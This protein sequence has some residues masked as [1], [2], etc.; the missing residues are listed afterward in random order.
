MRTV[1]TIL[2]LFLIIPVSG[3]R[4][5][6]RPLSKTRFLDS[7]RTPKYEVLS[8]ALH[9]ANA[10]GHA[11]KYEEA[12]QSYRRGYQT[13]QKWG[14]K[15]LAAQFLSGLGTCQF[16]S[17]RYGDALESYVAVRKMFEALGD[18]TNTARV[19]L[20][21]C[22]L[23]SQLGELGAAADAA[24]RALENLAPGDAGRR[25]KLLILLANLRRRQGNTEEAR[26]LFRA[27]LQEADRLGDVE[28]LSNGWDKLG[29][30]L[31]LEK[32]LGPAEQ[33]LFEAYRIRKL[34]RLPTLGST[35]RNLGML[36]LEQ[37]DLRSAAALFD[38][39][40]AE[41]KSG[42]GL[43]P[44]W[45][46]YQSRGVL[47]LAE[48]KLR[49]AY[50]DFRLAL[51]L[52]RNY[53]LATPAADA[54]RVSLEDFVEQAYDSFVE[55][56]SRLY[57]ERPAAELSRET[58]EAAEENRAGSLAARLDE[59]KR[60]RPSL[61][62][63]YWETV[64]QLESAE[65]AALLD[66]GEGPRVAV[67][68]IRASLIEMESHSG[69]PGVRLRP[70]LLHRVQES[71]DGRTALLS[72]HLAR[73]FSCL[74]AVSGSGFKL[75]RLPDRE[76][77]VRQALE[78]RRA[79]AGGDAQAERLG[80]RLYSA[81]FGALEPEFRNKSRWLLSLDEGLF[82]LPF[83][84]LVAG[85]EQ[86]A[87]TYL[88]ER[89]SL[90]TIS[91]AS[92]WEDGRSGEAPTEGV[93]VG[94]GDPVYNTADARWKGPGPVTQTGERPWQ[95]GLLWKVSAA[96]PTTL[97]LSR[98]AG[99]G[100]EIEACARE[101]TG[102]AALLEGRDATK[103]N[104][105]RALAAK[106][107]V[108][109]FATHVLEEPNPQAS[110]LIALSMSKNGHEELLGPAE[111]GGWDAHAG[112]IVLSGCSSGVGAA[113]PGA[114]L[115]GLTRAWLMAG[116]RAVVATGWQTPDDVGVFFHRF[117]RQLYGSPARDPA[118]ALEAAQIE[119]IRSHDWRS[120]PAVWAA[121]FA[122]GNY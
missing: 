90:R 87:P 51:E 70:D 62:A 48:G 72:F 115:M 104:V 26:E 67:R 102:P 53:R 7:A 96:A 110:G 114:G 19:D 94:V 44:E 18:P 103:E 37:G 66:R 112:L 109:H 14:Q 65:S 56:G 41:S 86:G 97:G 25:A 117:Y 122:M 50:A 84:A 39:S 30:G 16:L 64:A 40:I 45:R 91:G 8:M 21:L 116:A 2:C 106:P 79:V 71:L 85:G 98:L 42:R 32:Q 100:A 11:A 1:G 33:A 88:V 92:I 49:E 34:N 24:K 17:F 75:Y 59:R 81:I 55:T 61:P 121:Y 5:D 28:L 69:G 83:A 13:S 22:S 4:E 95:L 107:A 9:R 52:V 60:F 47:R 111:I 35:Y 74:W 29:A 120:Q 54:T 43:I 12:A 63:E 10:L 108:M 31:L 58:F 80:R 78:F 119:A 89:H 101:W 57:F 27:G 6:A 118:G 38:A 93:F 23:Y 46:F 105:R 99:S 20:N 3:R 36:R 82:D 113:H 77:I 76:S 15:E 68:R 73:G